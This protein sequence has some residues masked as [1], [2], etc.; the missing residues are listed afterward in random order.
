MKRIFKK[1]RDG[2]I[3]VRDVF[4]GHTQSV[5]LDDVHSSPIVNPNTFFTVLTLVVSTGWDYCT[6]HIETVYLNAVLPPDPPLFAE[7]P[8]A[9]PLRGEGFV[10]EIR[11][12]IYGMK[13]A[14]RLFFELVLK[15][16]ARAF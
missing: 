11:K 16:L 12:A 14:G 8:D 2:R 3:K 9:H 1:K 6:L 7:L 4:G 5:K 15:V 13:E 10:G